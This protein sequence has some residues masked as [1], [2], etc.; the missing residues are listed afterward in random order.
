MANEK[1]LQELRHAL[2]RNIQQIRKTKGLTQEELAEKAGLALTS[3]AYIEA[4]YNFPAFGTMYKISKVLGI[5]I[6]DLIPF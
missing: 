4:G 6:K 3:V 5:K 1:K 2:G